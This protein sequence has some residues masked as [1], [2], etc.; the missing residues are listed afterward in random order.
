MQNKSK[1]E[2]EKRK[3]KCK[4][5]ETEHWHQDFGKFRNFSTYLGV[6][7]PANFPSAVLREQAGR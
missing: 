3:I 1:T 2:K 4:Y 6:A 5:I 7:L